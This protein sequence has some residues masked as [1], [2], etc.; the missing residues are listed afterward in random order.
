[1]YDNVTQIPMTNTGRVR[2]YVRNQC[3]KG[4]KK[5]KKS[6]K[7]QYTRYRKLM[8]DMTLTPKVYTQLKRGFMGG[9]THSNPN[10]TDQV[11]N[12]VT[13]V[14]FTSSYPSVMVSELFPRGRFKKANIK[15]MERLDDYC[16]R[17]AVIFDI[18]FFN[19]RTKISQ[20]TYMSESKCFELVKPTISNGRVIAADEMA[21]TITDVDWEIIKGV[22][23]W[24][25][26]AFGEMH[27]ALKNYLPKPF[28][29]SVLELYQDKTVLK[30]V[31]GSEVE[32]LLSKGMLNSTYGMCVTDIAKDEVAYED[33]NWEVEKV[34]L[35]DT[36]AEYNESKSRFLYY[37][38]G[39][40]VT[41]YARRNLWTGIV[42][43]GDDYIYSDTD[44]LKILN[45][46]KHK[47]YFNLFNQNII[48][49]MNAMCDHYGFDRK[50]LHPKTRDGV[51]KTLGVWDY[52]GTYNRFKTLGAKRY[53]FEDDGRL[54]ITVAGLP[55]KSG[56]D[57]LLE[58]A[59][60]DLDKAFELF[61]D[62]LYIPANKTGK[63]THTYI[64]EPIELEV[65]DYFGN[66]TIVKVESGIHL[67]SCEFT[68]S[69][70][71]QYKTFLNNLSKGYIYQGTKYV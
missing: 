58:E 14:D 32:Y 55:K 12:D 31:E 48:E 59:N 33:G 27:Y 57:Y 53:L 36:I 11:L 45:Y 10:H 43:M 24:D 16:N 63:M 8:D 1:M 6:P 69:I 37:P 13:S 18:K 64:D 19:I 49:K 30:G 71:A 67:E 56:A 42:A 21:V 40:W 62:Q 60:G 4:G 66:R 61:S 54:E 5:G 9:F 20:E 70:S 41:A 7:G 68:L 28:I 65:V 22:Y 52:E 23:E 15:T 44:S 46:E 2:Q 47:P 51:V 39:L 26:V 25:S 34:S 29:K 38:W 17:Y 35:D 50:L 3:Y